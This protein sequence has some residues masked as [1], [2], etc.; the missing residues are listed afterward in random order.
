MEEEDSDGCKPFVVAKYYKSLEELKNDDDKTIYF[1]KKY[2][3]T[4]YGILSYVHISD[5]MQP[6]LT[7]HVN[8]I[9]GVPCEKR[10]AE[11]LREYVE[12][13]KPETLGFETLDPGDLRNLLRSGRLDVQ[14]KEL[15][16][17]LAEAA[18]DLARLQGQAALGIA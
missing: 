1:D 3:K 17:R 2:D 4:N 7:A 18:S 8:R 14:S 9:P 13:E 5:R 11:R 12:K 16:S 6:L 15:S 10:N